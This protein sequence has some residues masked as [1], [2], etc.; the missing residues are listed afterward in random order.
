M[1]PDTANQAA[2]GGREPSWVHDTPFGYS[3]DPMATSIPGKM[4]NPE[5]VSAWEVGYNWQVR[6][7]RFSRVGAESGVKDGP[8]CRAVR[9]G[10]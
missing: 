5:E 7:T 8:A 3:V 2:H 6:A 4:T 1:L 10:T 9:R